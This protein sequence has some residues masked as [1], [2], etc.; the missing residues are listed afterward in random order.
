MLHK[1]GTPGKR[2]GEFNLPHSDVMD[3]QGRLFVGDGENARIQLFDQSGRWLATWSGFAPHGLAFD[4]LG[5]L[6][7]ADAR[8]NPLIRL[9]ANGAIEERWGRKGTSPTGVRP[10]AHARV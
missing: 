9:T 7:L 5:R 2:D 3:S 8:A 4:K 10:A 6:Y 1:W